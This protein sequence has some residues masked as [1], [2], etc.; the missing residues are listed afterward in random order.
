MVNDSLDILSDLSLLFAPVERDLPNWAQYPI[1][2][3]LYR[4]LAEL[5]FEQPTAIQERALSVEIGATPFVEPP[6][7]AKPEEKEEEEE[8]EWGG[9]VDEETDSIPAA[10]T[11]AEPYV[12]LFP[13]EEPAS[14]APETTDRDIVGVAQTG[15]GKTLAYGLPILSWILNN[16]PDATPADG[17]HPSTR[18]AALIL[19]PTRELALQVRAAISEVAIRTNAMLPEDQ[20]DPHVNA[21]R[22]RVK[23]QHI[24]V[25][26][27]TGGMSV[28]KQKRQLSRGADILVATPGR[29]WDLIGE[30]DTLAKAIKGIKFLVI[31]EADRMI[32]NGHFA[33][34]ENIVRLTRRK[35][36]VWPSSQL[37]LPRLTLRRLYSEEV[38][39]DDFV[40]DFATAVTTAST[41]DKVEARPDMRTFVFSATMSK[42]LQRNLK[43]RGR[44][45][46]P[47]QPEDGMSSLGAPSQAHLV[48]GGDS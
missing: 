12:S 1:A 47:G 29:L 39:E 21:P 43:K 41:V 25:V 27:L 3:P 40:D 17:E 5:K 31:D 19:A 18:L 6:Y 45:Y 48:T 11:S 30:D 24:S 7:V 35:G 15:S 14:T 44:K 33:E 13:D 38:E 8:E 26:A 42:D 36:Y 23:G 10:T 32:E 9:I 20:Q 28:E 4:A 37:V 46:K 16:P 22:K 2:Q 34:L